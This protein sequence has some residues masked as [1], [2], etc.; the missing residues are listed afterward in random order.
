MTLR[1]ITEDMNFCE[2]CAV[3]VIVSPVHLASFKKMVI[4][5]LLWLAASFMSNMCLLIFCIRLKAI[6]SFGRSVREM[7]I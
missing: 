5:E 1:T 2:F 6:N 7:K 4:F 3:T